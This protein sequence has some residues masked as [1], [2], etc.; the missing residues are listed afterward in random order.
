MVDIR[1]KAAAE[2]DAV[3]RGED[4]HDDYSQAKANEHL[5]RS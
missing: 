2:T 4:N 3:E 5:G 1:D